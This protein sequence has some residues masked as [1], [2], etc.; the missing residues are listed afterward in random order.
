MALVSPGPR[1]R[2]LGLRM[3]ATRLV[4]LDHVA[5]VA[6]GVPH[7]MPSE[8]AGFESGRAEATLG[9]LCR[10]AAGPAR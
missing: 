10:A 4:V 2:G 7:P 1:L 9:G 6:C 3:S 8:D 5:W